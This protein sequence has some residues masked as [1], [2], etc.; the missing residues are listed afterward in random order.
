M[1]LSSKMTLAEALQRA[2]V[3]L[4]ENG[5]KDSPIKD[6]WQR[7][8]DWNYTQLIL[9]LKMP[10]NDE[11]AMRFNEVLKRVAQHEPIQ[12]I[13]G[14]ADFVGETYYVTPDTLIPREDTYGLIEMGSAFL[15]KHPQAKVLDIGTGSGIIAIELAKQLAPNQVTA[16]DI[17]PA[18]LAVAQKNGQH[19]QVQVEWLESDLMSTLKG[20][21][22]DLIVSNPPYIAEDELALMDESVKRFEPA[23]ALFAE[24]QGLAIYQRLAESLP[25]FLSINGQILLEIGF[26]QA[27]AVQAIFRKSFPNAIIS[28]H[29]DLNG[30]DRYIKIDTQKG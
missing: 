17:S 15:K 26:K 4:Q 22:F 28:V 3:F 29:Q 27:S 14:K 24:Q 8:F 11:Q 10:L 6:Y 7:T 13:L 12:Y 20:R 5:I 2:S 9:N 18:A 19:H 21:Q 1:V 30:L 23:T 25:S 16:V